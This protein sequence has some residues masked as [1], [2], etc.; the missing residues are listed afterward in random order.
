M[1]PKLRKFATLPLAALLAFGAAGCGTT[2]SQG[3][4]I[5]K[6]NADSQ[7]EPVTAVAGMISPNFSL[8]DY[9]GKRHDLSE[10]RGKPVLVN[11]WASWCGPCRQELPDLAAAST[12]LR[13]RLQIV[14]VNLAS[15]DAATVSQDLLKRNHVTYPNLL[16][17]EG[18]VA[19]AYGILVIPTS[20]LLDKNG[21]I[22]EKI[23]GPLTKELLEQH[24]QKLK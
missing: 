2:A 16:D 6:A 19:D 11:F 21:K 1:H 20:F 9:E 17:T 13:D 24:L 14:G 5:P 8:L 18:T 22:L 12:A 23:Q 3:V 15:Q 10:Y 4:L 7:A